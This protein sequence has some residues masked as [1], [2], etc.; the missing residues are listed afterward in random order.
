MSETMTL[1]QNAINWFEIPCEDLD[2][3]TLFYEKLLGAI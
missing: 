1:R 2:R 3:A